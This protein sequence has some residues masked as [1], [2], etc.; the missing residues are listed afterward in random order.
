MTQINMKTAELPMKT[1]SPV[2]M[3]PIFNNEIFYTTPENPINAIAS[4]PAVIKAI[5]VPFMPSGIFTKLICSRKPANRTSANPK[6]NAVEK[7]Y[8]TPVN[9][10]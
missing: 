4:K 3:N 5:G 8:T 6:P 1:E 10:L 7:A 2:V 9:R